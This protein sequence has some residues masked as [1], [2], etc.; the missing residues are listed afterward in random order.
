MDITPSKIAILKYFM[1]D[2]YALIKTKAN[3]MLQV[4]ITPRSVLNE[5]VTKFRNAVLSAYRLYKYAASSSLYSKN[6]IIL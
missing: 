2:N 5:K 6:E 1:L 4:L 3:S